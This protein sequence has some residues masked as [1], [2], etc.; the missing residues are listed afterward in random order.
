MAVMQSKQITDHLIGRNM[1]NLANRE[2]AHAAAPINWYEVAKLMHENAHILHAAPQGY[3]V[4]SDSKGSKKRNT[5][6]RAVFLLAAFALENLLKAFL[7]HANPN[8]IEGG[9]LSRK[10]L[11]GHSLSKLQ[12]DCKRVPSPQRSRHVFETLEVGVN[13]WAR[14]P[15]STSAERESQER[16][17]TPE[18][19]AAY[20]KVFELYSK[21]LEEL[22]SRRWK[23][24]YGEM[25]HVAFEISSVAARYSS[26]QA[27]V[28][29]S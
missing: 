1:D 14:Y 23:G 17:V 10:L 11:N 9:Q 22:L 16:T 19:W 24:P 13:S 8:Y 28:L 2:F 25:S 15:C 7:I 27:E 12:R 21:R 5:T 29:P 3:V 4:Y 26:P 20:N 18:F 6:N